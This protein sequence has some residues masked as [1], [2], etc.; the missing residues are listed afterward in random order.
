MLGQQIQSMCR[1]LIYQQSINNA[2]L[3]I[4]YPA[5]SSATGSNLF[6]LLPESSTSTSVIPPSSSTTIMCDHTAL[7]KASTL[8][9]SG[10][11]RKKRHTVSPAFRRQRREVRLGV[12]HLAS[13]I[14][15]KLSFSWHSFVSSPV[16]LAGLFHRH[17]RHSYS[18]PGVGGLAHCIS[19]SLLSWGAQGKHVLAVP[20]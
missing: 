13:S 20:S 4:Y 19:L 2:R 6:F 18:S 3:E 17:S 8:Q 7:G 1:Y 15:Q 11:K 16:S 9:S 10:G 5:Q 14:L 12:G